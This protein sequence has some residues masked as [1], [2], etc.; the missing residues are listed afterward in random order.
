MSQDG[1]DGFFFFSRNLSRD[2]VKD[3]HLAGDETEIL[4]E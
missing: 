3:A 2:T 1:D 4:G